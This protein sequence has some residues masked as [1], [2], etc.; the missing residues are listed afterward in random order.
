MPISYPL[1]NL[2]GLVETSIG[3]MVPIMKTEDL[4]EDPLQ[5]FAEPY[6]TLILDRTGFLGEIPQIPEFALKDNI[7]AW[8]DR[9]AFIHNLGHA[10]AAYFGY[11]VLP[12]S[13]YMHEVLADKRVFEYTR[14]VMEEAG[15]LLRAAYPDEFADEDITDHIN[16]LLSRFQNKNLGDTIFRVGSDLFRKLGPD[17]RF[18]APIRLAME[19]KVAYGM[20]LEAMAFGFLFRAKDENEQM[21]PGDIDFHKK[22]S[23]NPNQAYMQICGLQASSDFMLISELK[24]QIEKISHNNA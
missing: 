23:E 9:K 8:V 12:D 10:A 14:L 7:K 4:E 24:K 17:D 16:D 3:K 18:M 6:N 13:R 20:I 19:K 22:F 15:E 11:Y 1:E 21:F 5:V 2:V